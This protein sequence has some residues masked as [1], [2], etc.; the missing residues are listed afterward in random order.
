MA[1]STSVIAPRA[2][3]T[4]FGTV[5][6]EPMRTTIT[7]EAEQQAASGEDEVSNLSDLLR[8]RRSRRLSPLW[9]FGVLG[10]VL[11]VLIAIWAWKVLVGG[12]PDPPLLTNVIERPL[13]GASDLTPT[14][15][16][17]ASDIE[18]VGSD[19]YVMDRGNNRVLRLDETGALQA[20]LC[21]TGDCAFLLD[22]PQALLVAEDGVYV[23]NTNRGEV[24]LIASSNEV[25]ATFAMPEVEGGVDPRPAGL[26]L[27]P[28]GEL[29]VADAAN[30]WVVRFNIDGTEE[31]FVG[32]PGE[33]LEFAQPRGLA[34][35]DAGD[36]YVAEFDLGRIQK[37]SPEGRPLTTFSMVPGY[38]QISSPSDVE[39]T[40][41]GK[42]VLMADQ[43][44]SIVHVFSSGAGYLGIA[45]LL[46]ATRIDSPSA[47][48][49]PRGISIE[50]GMLYVLDGRR[51]IEVF[52]FDGE[53]WDQAP[54][55]R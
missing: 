6:A 17:E 50:N 7:P 37:I 26:A 36:L 53:Y 1:S 46:D 43:K 33:I 41:D 14:P 39:V 48:R 8:P 27:G 45:G 42:Y 34:V 3:T 40:P 44:R 51:G 13:P 29:Y 55:D 25:I 23:A 54:E 4:S 31:G 35:D 32:P 15:W 5:I 12:G 10:A 49:D 22:E 47:V 24:N 38:A 19:I 11:L 28:S 30:G 18:V 16:L 2:W 9:L 52:S 21:E 20:V